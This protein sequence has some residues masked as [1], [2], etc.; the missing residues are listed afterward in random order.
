MEG[1]RPILLA[2]E[3]ERGGEVEAH[4]P[5]VPTRRGVAPSR[6]LRGW[7]GLLR[8]RRPPSSLRGSLPRGAD[9]RSRS[10]RVPPHAPCCAGNYTFTK[11]ELTAYYPL[12]TQP[13]R[14]I[15]LETSLVR[16]SPKFVSKTLHSPG[17]MGRELAPAL[18]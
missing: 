16:G 3:G 6:A 13:C 10:S 2:R 8:L 18:G 1:L 14:T 4:R 15:I 7:R 12:S 5:S 9:G 17:P 11:S